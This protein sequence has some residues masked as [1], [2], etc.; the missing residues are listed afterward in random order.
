MR[1]PSLRIKLENLEN[2]LDSV[3]DNKLDASTFNAKMEEIDTRIESNS[4]DEAMD[5][6]SLEDMRNSLHELEN[7]VEG[8][9]DADEFYR[10]KEIVEGFGNEIEKILEKEDEKN[11]LE[12][13]KQNLDQTKE[14][15]K[16]LDSTSN[17]MRPEKISE[18]D[19]ESSREV[20]G[21]LKLRSKVSDYFLYT[22]IGENDEIIVKSRER[23]GEGDKTVRGKLKKL[24]EADGQLYLDLDA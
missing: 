22:L 1:Y 21:T 19:L 14:G 10:L 15:L 8:K 16:Q 6:E 11:S 13:L 9:P 3:S 23:L 12:S 20:R 17:A 24:D 4:E 7:T 2:R 18:K 5:R